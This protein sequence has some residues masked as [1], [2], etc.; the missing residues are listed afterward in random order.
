MNNK[1]KIHK[2]YKPQRLKG[3]DYKGTFCYSI[4]ICTDNKSLFFVTEKTVRFIESSLSEIAKNFEF[5][6]ICYCFMP[7][8]LHLLIQ[9]KNDDSD[10][11]SVFK[12]IIS[13][14][15]W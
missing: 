12:I 1:D 10:L 9:G 4:T 13:Q 7:D 11:W 8:H 15:T 14:K 3:F 2:Q 5:D 6:I